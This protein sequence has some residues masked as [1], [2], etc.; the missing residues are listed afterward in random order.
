MARNEGRGKA[1]A[2]RPADRVEALLEAGHHAAARAEARRV[3]ADGASTD[4]ARA[5]ADAALR[6]LAP[7]RAAAALGAVCVLAAITVG[8]WLLAH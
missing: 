5:R 6:S 1:R 3:L 7:E 8:A 4:E 2:H